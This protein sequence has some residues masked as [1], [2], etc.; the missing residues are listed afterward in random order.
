MSN[1][2][3]GTQMFY[4]RQSDGEAYCFSPVPLIAESE[5]RLKTN[6][7]DREAYLAIINTVTFNGILL[8]DIPALSGVSDDATCLELLDRKYDQLRSALNEDRGNL[9][10]VDSSGYPVLSVYPKVVSIDSEE[11]QMVAHKRYQ[12]VFEYESDITDGQRI[13]EYAEN[14]DFNYQDD[15][16]VS[17]AHTVSAVG[18]P[19]VPAG[20]GA[21]ANAKLFVLPRANSV[22]RDRARFLKSPYV[23]SPV[24][25]DNLTEY[26]HVRNER[27][28]EGRGSYEISESWILAS[29]SF[30]DDRTVEHSYNLNELGELIE[31]LSINGT[32]LGYGDTTYLRYNAAVAGFVNTVAPEIGFNAATGITNKSR[33]DNRFA[34]TVNYSLSYTPDS[35]ANALEDRGIQRSL[36]RNEDGTVTQTVTTTAKIRI[37]SAS[38]IEVAR[39]YCFAN[40]YPITFS[41]EPFFN[42]SLSGN[43]ESVSVEIDTLNKSY[44]LTRAFR[45]QGIPLYREEWQSNREQ[46]LE[47]AT[48]SVSIN[49]S[50]I[51]LGAES[52]TNTQIRFA[53]AS[54]AF[55]NDIEANL[56][57]RVLDLIPSGSCLTDQPVSKTVGYNKFNGIVT[58]DYRWDNRFLTSN[59]NIV[60][61]KIDVTYD[62]QG[63]VIAEIGIPGKPDGPILQ[64]Q[65]TKT[66]YQKNLKIQY[67]MRPSGSAL[68]SM[69]TSTQSLLE[70]EALRESNILVN[71][72]QLTSN[73]GE[74]PSASGVFK[75]ADQYTF[76][77]QSLVFTR[78]TTWKYTAG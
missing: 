48:V 61:E 47:S 72:T 20:T 10:I 70:T 71:N 14:W 41:V 74:K 29:G 8:P 51:G 11:S 43:I 24:D 19:D 53:Y 5:Q 59:P 65:Q 44:S 3:A 36:Q 35:S 25:I 27:I 38:G 22:K 58:Y 52:G 28:D 15:D 69:T 21:L 46:N 7:D 66:G 45:E 30:K 54:G 31:T 76:N 68:C 2:N 50:V 17:I 13:S 56:R 37:E 62:L 6:I 78:N 64:D 67:T 75:V 34:G 60:D 16:T 18:I 23:L 4:I 73:R 55:W 32:V 40:N 12:L 39:E 63:D 33:S 9:L 57:N 26:N 42:A 77:R 49:G 1:P